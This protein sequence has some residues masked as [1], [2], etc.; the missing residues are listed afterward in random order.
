VGG[1]D[2]NVAV[3]EGM[4]IVGIPVGQGKGLRVESGLLKIDSTTIA[5]TTVAT[6]VTIV[7]M[8]QIENFFILKMSL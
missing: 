7:K 1:S 2:L 3:G 5:T 6:S 8:S 4:L